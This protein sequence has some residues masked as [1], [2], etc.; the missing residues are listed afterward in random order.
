M[1]EA[2]AIADNPF[3]DPEEEAT[4]EALA[5]DDDAGE[6]L[7]PPAEA[8]QVEDDE[9]KAHVHKTVALGTFQKRVSKLVAQKNKAAERA[10]E[11]ER[12]AALI[13]GRL[14]EASKVSDVFNK[15]YKGNIDQLEWDARFLGAMEDLA[16]K[17]PVV[18]Q[19]AAKVKAA[20]K[21]SRPVTTTAAEQKPGAS[22]A[23]VE[24]LALKNIQTELVA[25]GVKPSF[26]KQIA[27]SAVGEYE[28]TDLV[29]ADKSAVVK[30]T[31][32]WLKNE[33][34]GAEEIMAP[35]AVADGEK[36]KP[37]T[38]SAGGGKSTTV[39]AK[40]AAPAEKP[41]T[42][43]DAVA[44]RDATREAAFAEFGERFERGELF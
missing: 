1:S 26:A 35:K 12:R 16:S 42:P 25:I 21:D 18:Q 2:L 4:P 13:E 22:D 3:A 19:A 7:I 9:T 20:M 10:E 24:A 38:A 44:A 37:A 6:E 39:P 23:V 40:K 33:G 30:L 27:K 34:F 11:A 43:A 28:A 15:V 5:D 31:K 32:T 17:D 41:K 29:S 14:Q 36:K 8:E